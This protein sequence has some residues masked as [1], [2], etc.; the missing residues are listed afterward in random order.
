MHKQSNCGCSTIH[1][2]EKCGK[3]LSNK[4]TLQTHRRSHTDTN[5]FL[6]KTCGKKFRTKNTLLIHTRIHTGERP[7]KCDHEQCEKSFMDRNSLN[8]HTSIH[9]GF[10][11]YICRNCGD[12]FSCHSNLRAHR[13][14]RK[15]TCGLLPLTD[16]LIKMNPT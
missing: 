12:R 10:K 2:C 8:L 14:V 11:R 3:V 15:N 6:C 9:T 5:T 1:K 13:R 4:Y 16:S 7:F